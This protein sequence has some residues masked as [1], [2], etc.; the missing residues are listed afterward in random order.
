MTRSAHEHLVDVTVRGGA[1]PNIGRPHAG[2]MLRITC[3]M[4]N[5]LVWAR[6]WD[7]QCVQ[8]R[9]RGYIRARHFLCPLPPQMVPPLVQE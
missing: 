8:R 6:C 7:R 1:C 2:H 9:G 4:L 3:D 5:E